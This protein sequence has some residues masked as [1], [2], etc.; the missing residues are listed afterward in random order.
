MFCLIP[1]ERFDAFLDSGV[2]ESAQLE[3]PG[4]A[5]MR[6]MRRVPAFGVCAWVWGSVVF[7]IGIASLALAFVRS[8]IETTGDRSISMRDKEKVNRVFTMTYQSGQVPE[9]LTSQGSTHCG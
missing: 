6:C 8:Q 9:T 7:G 3:Q 1:P 5:V 4:S 2:S